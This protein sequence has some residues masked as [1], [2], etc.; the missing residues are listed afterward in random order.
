MKKII[1]SIILFFCLCN[2][3]SAA[4]FL[5]IPA[6]AWIGSGILHVAGAAA[7][8]YYYLKQGSSA[9]MSSGGDFT[10]DSNVA[11]VDM[12][13]PV[14]IVTG[15]EIVA[16]LPLAAAQKMAADNTGKYPKS[17]AA[18]NE[19]AGNGAT[20]LSGTG[21][22]LPEGTLVNSGGK[23]YQI[24]SGG[25]DVPSTGFTILAC[26]V[27]LTFSAAPGGDLSRTTNFGVDASKHYFY[28]NSSGQ[29]SYQNVVEVSLP[30]I[31]VGKNP[32][33]SKTA[34]APL[35]LSPNDSQSLLLQAE[36][37]AMFQ[38]PSYVPN[39]TDATT[40]LP[41]EPPPDSSVMSPEDTDRYNKQVTLDNANTA[42]LGS[43][44]DRLGAATAGAAGAAGGVNDAQTKLDSNPTD[45]A[46]QKALADAQ[47]RL[48]QAQLEL[49]KAK[50]A[51]DKLKADIAKQELED[52]KN[53]STVPSTGEASTFNTDITAPE[54]K[55]ITGLLSSFVAS[56]P[57]VSMVKSFTMTASGSGVVAVGEVYG[58]D[59]NFDFSRWESTFRLLG[60]VLL[61]IMHGFAILVV[62]KGW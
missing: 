59:I 46:L 11:W 20:R 26:T 10:R 47:Y 37:D 13:G 25:G 49:A 54:K 4:A 55:G 19:Y 3:A 40:G 16:H 52:S 38:D 7:G 56:A 23:D 45:P 5:A 43:S 51:D 44:S 36:L 14:P 2:G 17:D 12:S 39:F 62:V 33:D 22:T 35:T 60:G 8:L 58:K 48:L 28:K 30:Q 29:T 1:A 50:A 21:A 53:T 34:L 57:L 9:K 61:V 41:Y 32:E 42:S 15:D 18:L 24:T 27:G 31:K 6:A